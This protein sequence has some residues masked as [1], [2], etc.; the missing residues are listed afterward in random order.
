MPPTQPTTITEALRRAIEAS[1]KTVNQIGAEAGV[2]HSVI[3][4]FQSGERDLRLETADKLATVL[5]VKVTV[6]T[7][8]Q[9]R[10]AT[11]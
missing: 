4:R 10:K 8:K 7:P 9:S 6:P 11:T 1:G 2:S 5:G 3:L